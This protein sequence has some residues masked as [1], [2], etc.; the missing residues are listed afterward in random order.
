MDITSSNLRILT[1]G[2]RAN[3]ATGLGAVAPMW[4][5][6]ATRVPSTT[7]DELY[8]WLNQIPGMRKW[9]GE[10]QLNNVKTD[11]YRLVNEDWEDTV[12]VARNAIEDD[13]YG[14]FAPLMSMLGD[15]AGR[16]PDELI[17]GLIPKG[18]STN[19]FDGQFFFDTDHPV[20]AADGTTGTVSNMQAGAGN[21]WFLLDTTKSL[22]P[23][24]FQDRKA[25]RFDA[26]DNP[27]DPNVFMR[28]EFIYGA[29]ARNT[30]G[31]GFWQTAFGSKAA[32][33]A[34]NFG[35]AFT[36][37]TS[38]RRDYGAPLAITPDVL[39]VGPSNRA[40]GEAIVKKANLAG[41]ESNLDYGRVELVVAPWL[42]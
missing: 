21:P 40:A 27:D 35:A 25:P 10:R 23:F 32:L 22:K 26:L 5:R 1:T 38:L 41:G 17:F 8:P 9:V 14:V 4:Q 33:D 19:C 20:I 11:A 3:F 7:S 2:F 18:F 29:D 6:F 15:A 30:G 12:T 31:F 39:L 16:Q 37:M 24:I 42:I 13:K 36:A 28:K 34:A